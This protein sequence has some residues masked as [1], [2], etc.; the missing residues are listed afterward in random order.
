MLRVQNDILKAIDRQH[1][2]FLVLLDLSAAFDTV[3]HVILLERMFSRFGVDGL[4]LRWFESYLSD[5][6]FQVSVQGGVSTSRSFQCGVPQGSILGPILFLMYTSPIGDI[7]REHCIDFHLYADDTQLY[8]TFETS[9][10]EEMEFAKCKVEAC[11]SEIDKWMMSNKLKL[12]T[13]KTEVL[14][15]SAAHRPRP[16]FESL[17]CCGHDISPKSTARNIGVIFDGK[18]SL[19]NQITSMCKSCFFH[20]KNIWKIRKFISFEA[21][22]TL[23]HAFISSRLDFCNSLLYG[24][25]KYLIQKLQRVQNA[26]ARLVSGC[27]KHDHITPVLYR[28]HW[29]PVEQRI[30]YKI[31]LLTF[32]ALNDCAPSYLSELVKPYVPPR[33]LRSKSSNLLTRGS[34]KLKSYGKRAFSNAAPELWN[35]IPSDIR[36]CLDISCFK[37]KLKTFLFKKAY[38]SN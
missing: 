25:P 27:H 23:V 15:L 5:R 4:A 33:S 26:A 19:E 12:N 8:V 2:V 36:Q 31:L 7:L 38:S 34:F 17:R 22:E 32:K 21:C 20:I 37:R 28:L 10:L 6:S 9:S 16:P 1:S 3:N 35:S 30:E 11:V 13:D 18:M 29:L 24:M 14:L